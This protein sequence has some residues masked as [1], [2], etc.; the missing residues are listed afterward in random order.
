MKA[1]A[2]NRKARYDYTILESLEAGIELKGSEVKSLRE[3][4]V[5]LKDSFAHIEKEEV[6]LSNLYIGPFSQS[7]DAKY[8]PLRL[9]KLL[10]H[11]REINRLA[12]KV[13]EK[14]MALIPLKLYFKRDLAK[15]E[16]AV[17]KGKRAYD[18]REKIKK[19][20]VEREMKKAAGYSKRF[21][22]SSPQGGK[23]VSTG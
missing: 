18:K 7:S 10:L 6:F 1:I 5:S 20:E 3:G 15:V 23:M 13:A 12:G 14:G 8:D 11:K 2:T 9:R 21:P 16:L 22:V 17:A 19:R 4:K